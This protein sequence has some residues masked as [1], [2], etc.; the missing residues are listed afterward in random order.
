VQSPLPTKLFFIF[1]F[2]LI[3]L[4]NHLRLSQ[5]LWDIKA[6]IESEAETLN[7][8]ELATGN[9]KNKVNK[10]REHIQNRKRKEEN[11]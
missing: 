2:K 11:L 4:A 1:I 8:A 9:T 6:V 10:I 7:N 5:F 3:Q